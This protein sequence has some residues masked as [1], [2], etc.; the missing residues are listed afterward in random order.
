MMRQVS[1]PQNKP[2]DIMCIGCYPDVYKIDMVINSEQG[3]VDGKEQ[4]LNWNK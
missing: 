3:Q 2:E 4:K 1:A